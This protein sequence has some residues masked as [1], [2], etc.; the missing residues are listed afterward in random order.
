MKIQVI[1]AVSMAFAATTI[2]FAATAHAENGYEFQSPSGNIACNLSSND[3]Q[4]FVACDIGDH[5][6]VSPPPPPSCH[7]GWGDRFALA[8]GNSPVMACHTD[9]LRIPGLPTLSYGQSRSLGTITCVSEPAWMSCTDTSTGN[10]FHVSR[11][12]YDMQ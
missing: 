9:T 2:G 3:G 7:G 6:Y 5:T 11:E 10:F 1:Q 4:G 8:Q 12:S